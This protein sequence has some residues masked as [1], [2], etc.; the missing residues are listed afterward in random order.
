[1]GARNMNDIIRKRKITAAQIRNNVLV[2]FND[3]EPSIVSNVRHLAHKV[4]FTARGCERSLNYNDEIT[5]VILMRIV[6]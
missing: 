4:I 6:G 3:G 2:D 1:M 5:I